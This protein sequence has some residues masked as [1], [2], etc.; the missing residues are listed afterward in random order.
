MMRH[1]IMQAEDATR[2]VFL[3]DGLTV[4]YILRR[5]RKRRRTVAFSVS[6]ERVLRIAAP[7][8]TSAGT[9]EQIIGRRAAWIMQRLAAARD[10]AQQ[11]QP[12]D[13]ASGADI[14][15][16]G[17]RL[18]LEVTEGGGG[19]PGCVRRGDVL[20]VTIGDAEP[21]FARQDV[22]HEI[23]RW[24][25]AQARDCLRVKMDYWSQRMGLAY[26]RL[27]ITSPK[28]QW[29]SCDAQDVIRLN[30]QIMFAP[31]GLVDYLIVHELCHVAHKDH[32][33]AFWGLVARHLPDYKERRALLRKNSAFYRLAD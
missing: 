32:S 16:L 6:P 18:R 24:Y 8:M 23:M 9:I 17:D 15:F 27:L 29:G 19:R 33:R 5:S 7:W 22:R 4:P 3:L 31:A 12:R 11:A 26:R 10:A 25:K 13:F 20:A 1:A 30:W 2:G 21:G 28:R 14:C